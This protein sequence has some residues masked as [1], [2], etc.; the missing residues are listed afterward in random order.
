MSNYQRVKFTPD[1]DEIIHIVI[2]VKVSDLTVITK[3]EL[4]RD[5][6]RG[7]FASVETDY[8]EVSMDGLDIVDLENNERLNEILEKEWL[9]CHYT[10]IP[11]PVPPLIVAIGPLLAH[12]FCRPVI[13]KVQDNSYRGGSMKKGGKTKYQRN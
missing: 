4:D 10:I 1:S 8:S 5:D 12:E 13:A 9:D 3:V 11:N 2:A 7:D 6:D